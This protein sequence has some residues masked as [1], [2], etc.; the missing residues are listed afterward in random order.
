M[1]LI[2]NFGDVDVVCCMFIEVNY[3]LVMEI[4]IEIWFECYCYVIDLNGILLNLVYWNYMLVELK[5]N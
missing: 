1:F 3:L 5:G 2:Y 4:K